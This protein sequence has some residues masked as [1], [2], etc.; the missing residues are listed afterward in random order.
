MRIYSNKDHQNR[1]NRIARYWRNDK[2][3]FLNMTLDEFREKIKEIKYKDIQGFKCQ[4]YI[5]LKDNDKNVRVLDTI[6]YR[7]LSITMF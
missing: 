5:I 4:N 6:S 1:R 3:T 7:F 2:V